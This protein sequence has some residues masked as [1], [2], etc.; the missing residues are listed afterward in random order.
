MT[1][2]A[3]AVMA[4]TGPTIWRRREEREVGMVNRQ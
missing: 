2:N 3:T 1:A 4:I